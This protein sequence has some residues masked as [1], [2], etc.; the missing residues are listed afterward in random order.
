MKS[1][2][3]VVV[4]V[5]VGWSQ[6]GKVTRLAASNNLKRTSTSQS[7]NCFDYPNQGGQRMTANDYVSDLKAY[8]MDNRIS[9]C[10]FTGI[11]LL[12]AD[13]N[14]NNQNHG[15]ANWWAYGD[16]Y[17]T[18]VPAQFD[19]QASSLR[20]TGAP[21]DMR[22]DTLNVYFNDYFIGD[23]E[24]AYNDKPKL[25]Y[26]NRAKSVIVT[27]CNPWTLYQYDNYH[28]QAMCVYPSDTNKCNPGFYTNAQSLGALAGQVSS[29]KRG[30]Y[31]NT[32]VL[33]DNHGV[34][35]SGN[36]ASGFFPIRK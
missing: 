10:C 15:A 12:Y 8:N 7:L 17:C 29:V 13:A 36:G 35:S 34:K 23:E 32:K 2:C 24:F 25:N 19:N 3:A 20:F 4:V 5:L 22:Y 16:N 33:P 9:S 21:D 18:N 6:A 31:S 28:G 30:C 27:G 1:I 26:D 14:Y 11:W